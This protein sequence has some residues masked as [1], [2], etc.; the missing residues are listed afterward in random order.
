MPIPTIRLENFRDGLEDLWYVKLL[1]QKLK[2][3]ESGTLKVKSEGW[4]LR[5]KSALAVPNTVA[6][7]GKDFSVDP[8][9]I[10]QWRNEMAD[11]IEGAGQPN[12]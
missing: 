9:V 11:L 2:E 6:R 5:A 10:Y 4:V 7:N 12:Q 1:E 8:E 3:V